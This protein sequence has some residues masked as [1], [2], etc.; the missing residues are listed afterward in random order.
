VS[1]NKKKG[2][3]LFDLSPLI[4]GSVVPMFHCFQPPFEIGASFDFGGF[5]KGKDDRAIKLPQNV[6]ETFGC[7]AQGRSDPSLLI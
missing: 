3:V 5:L 7:P 1:A 2:R 6:L 4:N